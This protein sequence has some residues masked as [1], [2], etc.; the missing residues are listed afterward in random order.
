MPTAV[1][2]L[3]RKASGAIVEYGEEKCAVLTFPPKNCELP[4]VTELIGTE[5]RITLE[6]PAHCPTRVS[7]RI[8]PSNGVPSQYRGN[9]TPV[10]GSA[11]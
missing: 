5:G 8:L 6:R 4:E 11:L 3:G 2:A 10:S 1:T 7:I 9:N